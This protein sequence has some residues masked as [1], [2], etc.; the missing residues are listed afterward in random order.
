MENQIS[1]EAFQAVDIRVGT[2]VDALPFPQ[3]HKPAYKLS[4]DFGPLIGVKK[5][6]AQLTVHYKPDQRRQNSR[7]G[8]QPQGVVLGQWLV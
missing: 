1:Y 5:S 8:P 7:R 6:S 3:A 4:I 2:I